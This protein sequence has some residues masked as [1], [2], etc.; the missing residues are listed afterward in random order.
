MN[1]TNGLCKNKCEN[2]PDCK[3]CGEISK[4]GF[5]KTPDNKLELE[6]N[7]QFQLDNV[8]GWVG[9]RRY[10][11]AL[12]KAECLVEALKELNNQ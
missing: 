2:Y 4:K 9:I 1:A 5:I 10:E 6:H 7:V 11:D 3:P 12:I 8:S